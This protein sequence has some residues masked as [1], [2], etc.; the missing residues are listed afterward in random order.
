MNEKYAIS[1]VKRYINDEIKRVDEVYSSSTDR[2]L[3][4]KCCRESG[5]L[6]RLFNKLEEFENRYF[7]KFQNDRE[8][9]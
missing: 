3:T 9:D 7:L 2:E 8:E 5:E 6:W 4:L 1:I